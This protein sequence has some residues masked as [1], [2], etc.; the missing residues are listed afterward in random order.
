MPHSK[1][2]EPE[3]YSSVL[4]NIRDLSGKKKAS[5]L[6]PVMRTMTKYLHKGDAE[7]LDATIYHILVS[8]HL[9]W[10]SSLNA[11]ASVD[12]YRKG[13]QQGDEP[14]PPLLLPSGERVLSRRRRCSF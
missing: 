14:H 13:R 10:G 8:A 5:A 3:T 12:A 9:R 1:Q 4:K 7:L 6:L 2:T 11:T